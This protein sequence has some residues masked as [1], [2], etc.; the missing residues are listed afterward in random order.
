MSI[1][2]APSKGKRTAQLTA[3]RH[4]RR[5][6]QPL[7]EGP[8]PQHLPQT[9]CSNA[10]FT[11]SNIGD[12]TSFCF[13]L[14]NGHSHE[15]FPATSC[16]A[17]WPLNVFELHRPELLEAAHPSG[18]LGQNCHDVLNI[19]ARRNAYANAPRIPHKPDR[20]L[21]TVF[22]HTHQELLELFGTS[23][24]A[25]LRCGLQRHQLLL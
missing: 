11:Q 10:G 16:G 23:H 4:L 20:P 15:D 19:P 3:A 5:C 7:A 8:P 2:H 14:L 13:E 12:F 25:P 21:I 24:L 1:M 6:R 22:V 17:L 18:V 9:I